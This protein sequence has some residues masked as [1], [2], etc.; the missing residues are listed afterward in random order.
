MD[1]NNEKVAFGGL[2][3]NLEHDRL[4]LPNKIDLHPNDFQI[5]L[6]E[7]DKVKQ[8]I[9]VVDNQGNNLYSID[10]ILEFF[11]RKSLNVTNCHLIKVVDGLVGLLPEANQVQNNFFGKTK[12]KQYIIEAR[13]GYINLRKGN[14]Y[15]KVENIISY[16]NRESENL[17]D[18]QDKA[19]LFGYLLEKYDM[20]Y[21]FK[22]PANL[23][24]NILLTNNDA[25][26][27]IKAWK[28]VGNRVPGFE[29]ASYKSGYGGRMES[30]GLGQLVQYHYDLEKCHQTVLEYLPSIR[31]LKMVSGGYS[32]DDIYSFSLISTKI[33][34]GFGFL[35]LPIK[36]EGGTSFN[37]GIDLVGWYPKPNVDLLYFLKIPFKVRESYRFVGDSKFYGF[38]SWT[39]EIKPVQNDPITKNSGFNMKWLY[40]PIAGKTYQIYR[41]LEEETLRNR[42]IAS[43]M[44]APGLYSHILGYENVAIWLIH[45]LVGGKT[46]NNLR[47]DAVSCNK[48][49]EPGIMNQISKYLGIGFKLR[50][51]CRGETLHFTF[52]HRHMPD[53][54]GAVYREGVEK[55]RNNSKA[56]FAIDSYVS[57]AKSEEVKLI[58]GTPVEYSLVQGADY[59]S[60]RNG[61]AIKKLGLLEEDYFESEPI[62]NPARVK[63]NDVWI[64][65]EEIRIL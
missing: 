27:E 24:S 9:Y 3:S 52:S 28:I 15:S 65:E 17:E 42:S 58:P 41:I 39:D 22:T 64:K 37:S 19:N 2:P 32:P 12:Y 38:K 34:S 30:M 63:S 33:P 53:G 4:I 44:F 5:F 59:G 48:T 35:P 61:T 10:N 55:N 60:N 43:S 50:E 21:N 57:V 18:L 45:Y 51:E 11:M 14:D 36:E 6:V 31:G 8:C 20:N 23:A 46:V 1:F 56:L 25:Y 47:N 40:L 54:R 7:W 16:T 62:N 49:I 13:R 26:R 29:E